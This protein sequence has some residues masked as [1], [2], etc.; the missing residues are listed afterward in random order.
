MEAGQKL[1]GPQEM[2]RKERVTV[3]QTGRQILREYSASAQ[4]TLETA[5]EAETE[6]LKQ[7]KQNFG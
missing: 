7:Q 4:W 5:E 2:K 3:E 6:I 1:D